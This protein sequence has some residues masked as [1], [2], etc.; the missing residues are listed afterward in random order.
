VPYFDSLVAVVDPHRPC[1]PCFTSETMVD[2][3]VLSSSNK[4]LTCA[5]P[6]FPRQSNA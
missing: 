2:K 1:S 6:Y 5:D 4:T 3:A